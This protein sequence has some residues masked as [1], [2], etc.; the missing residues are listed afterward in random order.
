MTTAKGKKVRARG[1]ECAEAGWPLVMEG[2]I[3]E[4]EGVPTNDKGIGGNEDGDE[5]EGMKEGT[6][7]TLDAKRF[8]SGKRN[9]ALASLA[10]S[11]RCVRGGIGTNT[12]RRTTT[13][14][15]L[16]HVPFRVIN[17]LSSTQT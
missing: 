12:I 4:Q 15:I 1:R 2:P 5:L 17:S 13:R 11:I 8:Y 3:G 16:R 10:I 7:I 14:T 9:F 6:E